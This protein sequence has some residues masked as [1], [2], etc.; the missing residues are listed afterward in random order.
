METTSNH[1]LTQELMEIGVDTALDFHATHC[2]EITVEDEDE[3]EE[4]GE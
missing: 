1:P 2:F 3:E 4:K